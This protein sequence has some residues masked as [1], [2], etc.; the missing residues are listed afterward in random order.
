MPTRP[1][2][3]SVGKPLR[4]EFRHHGSARKGHLKSQHSIATLTLAVT[5]QHTGRTSYVVVPFPKL[6]T[7]DVAFL[8]RSAPGLK[9]PAAWST[10]TCTTSGVPFHSP[11]PHGPSTM[12][13]LSIRIHSE[14]IVYR[15]Y[16]IRMYSKSLVRSYRCRY[17]H[18]RCKFAPIRWI[19]A[20]TARLPM[21][22]TT[23][24]NKRRAMKC[25]EKNGREKT[26]LTPFRDRIKHTVTYCA[27][28]N[29]AFNFL[30]A[31]LSAPCC[32]DLEIKAT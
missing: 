2:Q 32:G 30:P 4:G 12:N 9:G 27:G 10:K 22:R 28:T 13:P 6:V 24:L 1:Y 26:I 14:S 5:N 7:L 3:A 31:T 17:S 18:C 11:W 25:R 19:Q 15:V 21:R 23:L 20:S 8:H 16:R 29:C